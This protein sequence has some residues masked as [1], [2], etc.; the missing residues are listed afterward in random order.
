VEQ[1][2]TEERYDIDLAQR[3]E[4][5]PQKR[6]PPKSARLHSEIGPESRERPTIAAAERTPRLEAGGCG[7]VALPEGNVVGVVRGTV[8]P[9]VAVAQNG[10]QL[11]T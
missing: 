5:T 10:R 8:D 2:H 3:S 4:E 9:R 6:P 11:G 7:D 1:K